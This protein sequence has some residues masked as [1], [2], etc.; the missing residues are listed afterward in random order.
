MAR[1][2]SQAATP[3]ELADLAR[4]F[5]T[6]ANPPADIPY[7]ALARLPRLQ[8]EARADLRVNAVLA[9]SPQACVALM[10]GGALVLMAG[11]GSLKCDFAWA[12]AVLLGV[13]A[14]TR[15]YIR[16]FAR[17]LRR[18]PLQDAVSDL[19]A[20]LLYTGMAWGAGAYLVMPGLPAPVFA[21]LFAA[22]PA[23]VLALIVRDEKSA[24]AFCIPVTILSAAAA[25][26]QAWPADTIVAAIILFAGTAAAFLPAFI[27]MMRARTET[28]TS[29]R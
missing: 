7:A 21:V 20:V 4:D 18:V 25:L 2:D 9:R 14:M 12:A 17:S 10:L 24:A 28:F 23:F 29:L 5:L 27:A 11:D 19:R 3:F 13:L 15:N 26:L 22:T 6:A 8:D 16:G 1:N